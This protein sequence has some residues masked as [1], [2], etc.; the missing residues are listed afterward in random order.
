MK[1]SEFDYN[2]PKNLI[3]NKLASPRDSSKFLVVNYIDKKYSHHIFRDIYDILERGDILVFNDTKVFP[4]RLIGNK[5]SS[6]KV[7]VFLLQQ[8]IPEVQQTLN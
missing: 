4:A 2:L 8:I 7:E 5:E 3:A 1:T 6:G